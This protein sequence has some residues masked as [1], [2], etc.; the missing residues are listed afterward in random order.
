[1]PFSLG[2]SQT[3]EF[4]ALD[5]GDGLEHRELVARMSYLT[6]KS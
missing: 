4:Q 1:M 5:I 6:G 2:A 3:L